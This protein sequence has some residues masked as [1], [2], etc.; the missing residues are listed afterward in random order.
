MHNY[1]LE[2]IKSLD[3]KLYHLEYHQ[4]RFESVLS[5]LGV[6]K[7]PQ[8]IHFID[9]PKDALVRCRVLYS[10]DTLS[11][12]YHPYTIKNIQNIKLIEDNNIEYTQKSAD[13]S[14]LDRLFAKRD[15]CDDVLIVKNGLL[16]DTTIANIALFRD[17]IWYTPYAPL[18]NGTTRMRLLDE[19]KIIKKNIYADDIKLYTKVA[20]LNAMIGFYEKDINILKI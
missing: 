19:K 18:L 14:A 9:P 4:R 13:R 10:K 15:E 11:V 12:S 3:G 5:S 1:F 6:K 16:C 7:F 20:L 8:L 2:T 17:G